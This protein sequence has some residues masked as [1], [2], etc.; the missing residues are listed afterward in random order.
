MAHWAQLISNL[1]GWSILTDSDSQIQIS[2]KR[3]VA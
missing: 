3:I 1:A 2:K